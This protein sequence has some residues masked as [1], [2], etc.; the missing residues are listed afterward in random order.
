MSRFL[1]TDGFKWID[2]KKF[3]S[4][5]YSSNSSKG[6][7]LEPYLKYLKELCELRNDYSSAPGKIE[8]KNEMLPNDQL[9]ITD[10]YNIATGNVTKLVPNFFDKERNVLFLYKNLI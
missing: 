1:P 6:W 8:I 9:K 7:V 3:D 5:K 4:N 2:L 10:F